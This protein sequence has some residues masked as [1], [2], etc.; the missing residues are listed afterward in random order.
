MSH[1]RI[2]FVVDREVI[3]SLLPV[4]IAAAEALQGR[5]AVKVELPADAADLAE[6]WRESL[7]EALGH[8]VASLLSFLQNP[9][10][11]EGAITLDEGPAE[12]VMRACSAVRLRIRETLLGGIA[13]RHLETGRVNVGRLA[14][15]QRRAY[16]CYILLA[17]L[18]E[19]IIESLD[20]GLLDDPAN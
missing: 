12:G 11:A 13:D 6:G 8:D 15:D 19:S 20:P 9:A 18:Q 3:E 14:L 2:E 16:F 1:I 17:G 4:M 5:T 10:L 7:S